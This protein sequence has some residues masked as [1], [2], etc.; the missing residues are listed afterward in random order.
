MKI[1]VGFALL[2]ALVLPAAA[3]AQDPGMNEVVVTGSRIPRNSS[4]MTI[5]SRS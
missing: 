3:L 4:T 2:S 1:A 5:P